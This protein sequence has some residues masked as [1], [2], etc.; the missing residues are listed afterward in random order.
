MDPM[1]MQLIAARSGIPAE[2]LAGE[3]ADPRALLMNLLTQREQ[4]RDEEQGEEEVVEEVPAAP[5]DPLQTRKT[6][7]IVAE[8]HA[9]RR[10]SD[11]LAAALGA[12][13]LCW[14]ADPSC[15][16]CFGAGRAGWGAIDESA[17]REYV[18]PVLR[19]KRAVNTVTVPSAPAE[20]LTNNATIERMT[21]H[22]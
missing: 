4:A 14:G 21:S 13:Y 20:A 2:A 12:C 9:L 7:M 22:E 11:D 15:V 16:R 10:R 17:F 8:L 3:G 19:R 18:L 5:P 6:R 1:L